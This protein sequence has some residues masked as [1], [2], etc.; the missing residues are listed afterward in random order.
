MARRNSYNRKE[1]RTKKHANNHNQQKQKY[2][3]IQRP[4]ANDNQGAYSTGPKKKHNKISG[5]LQN[6]DIDVESICFEE[7]GSTSPFWRM[8]DQ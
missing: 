3:N 5:T 1:H 7:F 6:I 8:E 4:T 2:P